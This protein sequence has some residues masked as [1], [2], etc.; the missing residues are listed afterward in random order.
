[1]K[2][3]PAIVQVVLHASGGSPN[4]TGWAQR[5]QLR[6]WQPLMVLQQRSKL[7]LS[8]SMTALHS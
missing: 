4:L 8:A 1:M 5:Q 2:L 6:S 7:R 3:S